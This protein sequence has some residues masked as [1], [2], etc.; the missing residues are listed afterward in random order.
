MAGGRGTREDWDTLFPSH[1]G[2]KC[3]RL[4]VSIPSTSE[5]TPVY[6]LAMTHRESIC[7]YSICC[8]WLRTQEVPTSGC[9]QKP[10]SG[11]KVAGAFLHSGALFGTR[12]AHVTGGSGIIGARSSSYKLQLLLYSLKN[13]GNQFVLESSVSWTSSN[14]R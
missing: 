10:P 13:N 11:K 5:P 9:P 14:N 3:G 7:N 8:W 6:Q 12:Q 4:A 2:N 1:H